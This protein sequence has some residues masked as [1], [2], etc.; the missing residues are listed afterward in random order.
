M[1]FLLVFIGGGLGSCLRYGI[2]KWIPIRPDQF[3][4]ATILANL[5]SCILIGLLIG[6]A[7][8]SAITSTQKLLLVTGFCGGFSTFSTFSAEIF[9][10][11]KLG[12]FSTV[13]I[14]LLLSVVVGVALVFLGVYWSG[15]LKVGF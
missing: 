12:Q 14:Y 5:F 9:T 15:G 3:P 7:S 2:S 6:Y 10:L 8:K 1:N 4:T 11:I 13:I